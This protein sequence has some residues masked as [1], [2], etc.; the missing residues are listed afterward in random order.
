[1]GS[2]YTQLI[3]AD[4]RWMLNNW[5]SQIAMAATPRLLREVIARPDR[6]GAL[7]AAMGATTIA[8]LQVPATVDLAARDGGVYVYAGTRL[9]RGDV[10][11]R[12]IWDHKPPAIHLLNALG[13]LLA[14]ESPWGVWLLA[15]AAL[16]LAAVLAY[17]T[18]SRLF[19]PVAAGV[20]SVL[21]LAGLAQLMAGINVPE[22]F[23]LPLG[24]GVL[25]LTPALADPRRGVRPWLLL[26]LLAAGAALLKPNLI[27]TPA[28]A[29]LVGALLRARVVGG[30]QTLVG[31]A[32][33]V[34]VGSLTLAGAMLPFAVSAGLPSVLDAVVGYNLAYSSITAAG[35][36]RAVLVAWAGL[37][38]T[39]LPVAAAAS[40]LVL[41]LGA[42][43]RLGIGP[44]AAIVWAAI[45]AL[46][47]EIALSSGSGRLYGQYYLPW[48][49]PCAVLVA[50]LLYALRA[51]AGGLLAGRPVARRRL[52]AALLTLT[53]LAPAAGLA[54]LASVAEQAATM[55]GL[56]RD[57]AEVVRASTAPGETIVVW[58]A[59][60]AVHV[61]A[62]RPAPSRFVYHYP[63]FTARAD[64]GMAIREFGAD[65]ERR[66]PR[67]IIDT[68]ATNSDVPPLDPAQR[69]TWRAALPA[70]AGSP[71]LEALLDTVGERYAPTGTIGSSG[72]RVYTLRGP[73]SAG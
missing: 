62:E 58:G 47:V 35:R 37:T 49:P 20:G 5:S 48:L 72:W 29:L 71:A 2:I 59:E 51:P 69:A 46:P 67:L 56:L 3:I 43:R 45:I 53:V 65:L 33:A 26:G 1:L 17:R 70:Y 16:V 25:A 38:P 7:L 63:L 14:G 23:A 68:S 10:L 64:T 15:S 18:L 42:H 54:S 32:L 66:P 4:L 52:V 39:L 27:G 24:F 44:R 34:L 28:A 50:F 30:G 36:L 8:L 12:D 13:L 21:W 60:S 31:P 11:Y 19:A 41:V 40:W 55:H 57:A 6:I 61:L 22:V 73:R 9:L